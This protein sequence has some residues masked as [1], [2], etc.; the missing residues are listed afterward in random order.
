MP[1]VGYFERKKVDRLKIVFWGSLLMAASYFALLINFWA[2]MLV[3]SILFITI[4]EMFAFPFSNSFAMSR[5]PK[6]HEGRYMALYTMSF[7]LAHIM[8]AKV[9][10]GIVD[11]YDGDYRANW[12]FMG[13]LGLASAGAALYLRKMMH[14][15]YN[16]L[17]I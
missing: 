11:Y 7:S 1:I 15:N 4:G 12:I 5:A 10:M 16:K 3:I 17:K 2:G 14:G 13:I 6:G 9:G 8:S